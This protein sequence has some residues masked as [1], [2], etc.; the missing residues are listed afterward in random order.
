MVE[1]FSLSQNLTKKI[2]YVGKK[3]DHWGLSYAPAKFVQISPSNSR[4]TLA[5]I[6]TNFAGS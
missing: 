6:H 1:S 2:R 3:S 5:E 4:A